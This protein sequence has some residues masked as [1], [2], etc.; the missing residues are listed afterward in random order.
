VNQLTIHTQISS[1]QNCATKGL[2]SRH[3]NSTQ[4]KAQAQ[5]QGTRR[6]LSLAQGAKIDESQTLNPTQTIA[7]LWAR[8]KAS[9]QSKHE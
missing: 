1:L 2:S 3:L 6:R 7:F 4:L 5:A 8:L 9:T